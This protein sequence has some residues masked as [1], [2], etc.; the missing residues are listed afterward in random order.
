M[1]GGRSA[2]RIALLHRKIRFG[3]DGLGSIAGEKCSN[4]NQLSRVSCIPD[5]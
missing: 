4:L 3:E 5:F 1:T 2:H